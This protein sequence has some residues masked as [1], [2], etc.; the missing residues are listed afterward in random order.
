MF[1]SFVTVVTVAG[2]VKPV[3]TACKKELNAWCNSQTSCVRLIQKDGFKLPL[4]ALDDYGSEGEKAGKSWRCYSPSALSPNRS[5]YIGGKAYCSSPELA[6]ALSLCSNPKVY[7][8]ATLLF[9]AAE[10]AKCGYIRTPQP[11]LAASGKILLFA[12]CRDTQGAR[13]IEFSKKSLRDDFR[14]CRMVLKTSLDFGITWSPMQFV[15][16]EGTGVGVAI[17]DQIRNATVFQYQTMPYEDPYRSNTLWQKISTDEGQSWSTPSNI[18]SQINAVCNSDKLN[19]MVCGAAGSRIQ[20]TAGRL[21]FSGH[22][23]AQV[24]VWFSDDGGST[25][26]TSAK[27]FAG[28][29]QSIAQLSDGSLYMNG[30]AYYPPAPWRPNRTA[31]RSFDGGRTWSAPRPTPIRGVDC[32]AAVIAVPSDQ[33]ENSTLVLSQPAGPGR[34][35]FSLYCSCDNGVTWPHSLTVNPGSTAAY[36]GL[37]QVNLKP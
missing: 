11:I 4:V 8:N 2:V 24:C 16:E 30:R 3:P 25:Y 28:D 15:S 10:V 1:L 21:V 26:N 20:T 33:G 22:N 32:E 36:S 31:W 13:S 18:T 37:L 23:K 6:A 19:E 17:F 14:R 34:V 7:V 9:T 5:S 35:S 27:A 29:E 12:Q